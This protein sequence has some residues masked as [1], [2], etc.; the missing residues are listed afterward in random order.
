MYK[1]NLTSVNSFCSKG[2]RRIFIGMILQ[3]HWDEFRKPLG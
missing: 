2:Q 3:D 1:D